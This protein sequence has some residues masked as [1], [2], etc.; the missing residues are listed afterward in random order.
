MRAAGVTLEL[1]LTAL[2]ARLW[3]MVRPPSGEMLKVD[4][5]TWF[6]PR[7]GRAADGD[8]AAAVVLALVAAFGMMGRCQGSE[9]EE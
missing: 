7:D 3:W 5:V 8:V 1:P 9:R 4:E 6:R 2:E